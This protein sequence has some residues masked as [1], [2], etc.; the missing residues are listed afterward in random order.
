ME[1]SEPVIRNP[2]QD[3]VAAAPHRASLKIRILPDSTASFPTRD[4]WSRRRRSDRL[5]ARRLADVDDVRARL[6]RGRNDADV[7]A[8]LRCERF[9]FARARRRDSP[10]S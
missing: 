3:L 4:F 7:D 1:L 9:G 2:R 5:G 10:T 8:A 6:L